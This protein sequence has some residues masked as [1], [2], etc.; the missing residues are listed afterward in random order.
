MKYF[1]VA[2]ETSGDNH[3]ARLMRSLRALDKNAFF[4]GFGG[5]QMESEGL[6]KHLDIDNLAFMGIWDVVKNFNRIK[7]YLRYCK[8]KI[9]SSNPDVVILVDYPGFNLKIAEFA[10]MKGYKVV[11]YIP[12]KVWASRPHR[13]KKLKKYTNLVLSILPFEESYFK[14]NGLNVA[15]VGNPVLE[16]VNESNSQILSADEF[17]HKHN[18]SEKPI[19]AILPGSRQG[20]IKNI[21]P[22]FAEVIPDFPKYQFVVSGMTIHDDILYKISGCG[23]P[24]VYDDVYNL[25]ANAQAAMVAS[26]TATLET[27]LFKVPQIVG[28]VLS[29]GY[30]T[31]L[32]VK[33]FI[34]K[35][36]FISLINLIAEK[37][38][39]DELIQH[40]LNRFSLRKSLKSLLGDEG[41][42]QILTEY[43]KVKDKL[44]KENSASENAASRIFD[45]I[46]R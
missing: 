39:V 35:V 26:G 45:L 4:E 33:V 17:R 6:E 18:L 3:A 5:R 31:F 16:A 36:K 8:Q 10:S 2:G 46:E 44:H 32:I 29:G 23:I 14:T 30:F 9:S 1:I 42:N 40:N 43:N 37:K 34:V 20:E 15:Y 41:K 28:Y 21:L 12:P 7:E 24:V 25:L 38:V 22:R 13:I 27:A 19:I 11:Y